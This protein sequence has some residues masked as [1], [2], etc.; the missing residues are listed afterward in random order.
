MTVTETIGTEVSFRT[1]LMGFDRR[2]VRSFIA[3]LVDDYARTRRE[4]EQ[5]NTGREPAAGPPSAAPELATREMQRILA[6]AHRVADEIEQRAAEESARTLADAQSRAA[7]IVAGAE[8]RA[9]D[10][11]E[12]A[13]REV[14]RLE[15]R[16]AALRAHC[17]KLRDSFESAADAA[18][19]AVEDI[20]ALQRE[21]GTPSTSVVAT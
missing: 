4:L 11:T 17:L 14:T 19:K 10:I 12:A 2:E 15:E 13:R 3:N 20:A 18:S 9:L 8:Q 7:E 5:R 1:R 16:A 6:G 21:V